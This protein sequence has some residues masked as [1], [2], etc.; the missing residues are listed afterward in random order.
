MQSKAAKR[1]AFSVRDKAGVH[2]FAGTRPREWRLA[3]RGQQS[4]RS[5]HRY[6]PAFSARL[7]S[8]PEHWNPARA[9]ASASSL[10][11]EKIA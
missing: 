9:V 5:H 4:P 11:G 1:A 3:A 10:P 7:I 8:S 2:F 6:Q